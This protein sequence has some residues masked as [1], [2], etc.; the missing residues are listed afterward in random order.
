MA[1]K[2]P[3]KIGAAK[4]AK[5][6]KTVKARP[7]RPTVGGV[8]GNVA[9]ILPESGEAIPGGRIPRAAPTSSKPYAELQIG[10]LNNE[11]DSAFQKTFERM[12]RDGAPEFAKLS[13]KEFFDDVSGT[14]FEGKTSDNPH[15]REAAEELRPLFEDIARVNGNEAVFEE[16]AGK[17][18]AGAAEEVTGP[19]EA[20]M[21]LEEA[22]PG[23]LPGERSMPP[24]EGQ[25]P[26]ES[27]VEAGG[28]P[29]EALPEADMTLP[30]E[31]GAYPEEELDGEDV[32][33][34]IS[35][36]RRG[37]LLRDLEILTT[38]D[39]KPRRP[40]E[41]VNRIANWYLESEG[42]P[43]KTGIA[44]GF[45]AKNDILGN[46]SERGTGLI[47]LPKVH[48]IEKQRVLDIPT[49]EIE[50][51]VVLGS[52]PIKKLTIPFSC[53]FWVH[54][55]GRCGAYRTAEDLFSEVA[56]QTARR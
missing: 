50:D 29:Y 2:I 25:G 1:P 37:E 34:P 41:F 27:A 56:R 11:I 26:L 14:L 30:G 28:E 39:E 7:P 10:R 45:K 17:P 47:H 13:K 48:G 49:S 3:A 38:L 15:A 36:E 31:D 33:V 54:G 42:I 9:K 22:Q 5:A 16:M 51:F 44:I 24:A 21:A 40:L 18:V 8:P 43:Q 32:E 6:A 4:A 19:A 55:I 46:S 35:E 23:E 20:E 52:G 12:Q 53:V